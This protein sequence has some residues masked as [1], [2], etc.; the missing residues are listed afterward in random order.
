M[1]GVRIQLRLRAGVAEVKVLEG[2]IDLL[3]QALSAPSTAILPPYVPLVLGGIGL[4]Y[5][6]ASSPR[7]GEAEQ[8][9]G[10]LRA[11]PPEPPLRLAPA[12][13]L[14]PRPRQAGR[15]ALSLLLVGALSGAAAVS[16]WAAGRR[17]TAGP[18]S[19]QAVRD[20]LARD[21]FKGLGVTR[22]RDGRLVV[23]GLLADDAAAARLLAAVRAR[24]TPVR[25]DVQTND[26]LAR[27]VQDAFRAGGVETTVRSAGPGALVVTPLGG[28]PEAWA[29]LRLRALETAP[30]LR[31]LDVVPPTL[32]PYGGTLAPGDPGKRVTAL[33][34]GPD[35]YVITADGARYFPGAELPGGERL[36]AVAPDQLTLSRP[37]R[38][39]HLYFQP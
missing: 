6:E 17:V 12:Q 26:G 2:A 38:T 7:W 25:L 13:D 14:G 19:V 4:G 11:P 5:G 34:A 9:L 32:D 33:V 21:G 31:R 3:G 35:G 30:G 24:G 16:L 23:H 15:L 18:P 1:K 20:G 28:G 22:A 39:T 10:A 27:R 37:G 29:R 8:L 36:T